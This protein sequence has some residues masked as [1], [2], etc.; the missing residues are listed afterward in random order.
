MPLLKNL[1]LLLVLV[2]PVVIAANISVVGTNPEII[3]KNPSSRN[4]VVGGCVSMV[5]PNRRE[6]V[7]TLHFLSST[8]YWLGAIASMLPLPGVPGR[9]NFRGFGYCASTI[10]LSIYWGRGGDLIRL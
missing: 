2:I 9:W 5:S 8:I 6:V 1:W 3:P 4:A 10:R 7:L